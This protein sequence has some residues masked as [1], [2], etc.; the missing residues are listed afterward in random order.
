ML[1]QFTESL[2]LLIAL[3]LPSERVLRDYKNYFTPKAGINKENVDELQK[4]VSNFSEVQRHIVLVK[5]EMKI[6]SGLVF[7]KHSTNVV[8]F[9]DLGDLMTNFACLQDED[10]LATHALAFLVRGLCTD[11]KHVIAYFFTE[12]VTSFQLMPIFW[13][14]VSTLE[15]SLN[16]YVL[17]LVNDG[18]SPNRKLFNLHMKLVDDPNCDVVFKTINLFPTTHQFIYLFADSPHLMKTVRNCLYNSGSG[19]CSRLMWNNGRYLLF[20]HIAD[21][22]Y[23]DQNLHCMFFQN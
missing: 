13:K 6:Q 17:G 11:L 3:V 2:H 9:I 5:D 12:N 10:T 20:R 15:L 7:D 23:K 8:G 18:A 4:K 21:L 22:F 1:G 16:L 19:A 14:V